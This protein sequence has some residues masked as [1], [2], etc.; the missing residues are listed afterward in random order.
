[1]PGRLHPVV[2]TNYMFVK[3]KSYC[4][5]WK[6]KCIAWFCASLY[7]AFSVTSGCPLLGAPRYGVAPSGLAGV[8]GRA[9]RRGR[10]VS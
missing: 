5:F 3:N 4:W 9:R 2:I 7:G 8:L 6:K 1:M 10:P